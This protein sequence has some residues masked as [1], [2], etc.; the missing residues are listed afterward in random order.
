[1]QQAGV[2]Q[3]KRSRS[4][5][6]Y[7]LLPALDRHWVCSLP[8]LVDREPGGHVNHAEAVSG[9]GEKL[10]LLGNVW[11]M[12]FSTEGSSVVPTLAPSMCLSVSLSCFLF[13]SNFTDAEV[14][15]GGPRA[16]ATEGHEM[17]KTY[18]KTP[19]IFLKV[20]KAAQTRTSLRT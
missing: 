13:A 19:I 18:H 1:M 2:T 15:R 5:W 10:M 17:L 3:G 6:S 11:S 14:L 9:K 12:V 4:G 16:Q 7:R 8:S 20:R